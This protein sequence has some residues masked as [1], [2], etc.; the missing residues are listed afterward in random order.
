MFTRRTFFWTSA[1]ALIGDRAT[2][3]THDER[4]ARIENARRLMTRH[5]IDAIMLTQ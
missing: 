3:I 2:P 4:R 1:A 5:K